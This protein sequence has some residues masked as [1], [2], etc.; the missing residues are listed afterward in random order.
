MQRSMQESSCQINNNAGVINV[1]VILLDQCRSHLADVPDN[2]ILYQITEDFARSSGI[3]GEIQGNRGKN[4]KEAI[5][6]MSQK[7][8][9]S[10][11]YIAQ[12]DKEIMLRIV[13]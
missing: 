12:I 1:G 10:D 13:F 8:T 9:I 3:S 4:T 11:I 2:E 6:Q 5:Q 7:R